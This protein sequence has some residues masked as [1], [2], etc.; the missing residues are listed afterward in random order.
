MADRPPLTGVGF[1]TTPS[2]MGETGKTQGESGHGRRFHPVDILLF[3]R[4]RVTGL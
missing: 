4:F 2:R 3:N 1:S